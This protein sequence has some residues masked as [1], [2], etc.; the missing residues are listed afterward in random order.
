M[1]YWWCLKH[2]RVEQAGNKIGF[3]HHRLGPFDTEPA[4][5]HAVAHA[6]ERA[7]AQDADDEAWREGR[8][9]R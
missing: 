1:A 8:A 3:F 7:A 6:H 2:G 4:A 5:A 9:E